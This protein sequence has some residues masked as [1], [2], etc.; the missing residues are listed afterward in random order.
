MGWFASI[1]T[2]LGVAVL[3][4]RLGYLIL[5]VGNIL[6]MFEGFE[7]NDND[8]VT[9]N[10]ILAILTARAGGKELDK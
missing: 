4:R 7:R 8:I 1:F 5:F 10:A 6:W 9:L 2:V 3:P